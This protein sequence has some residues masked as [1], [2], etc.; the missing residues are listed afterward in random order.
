MKI[1][2]NA[3]KNV[4]AC[5][6]LFP[7]YIWGNKIEQ[8]KENTDLQFYAQYLGCNVDSIPQIQGYERTE[9]LESGD[10][11]STWKAFLFSCDGHNVVIMETNWLDSVHINRI[12]IVSEQIRKDDIFIGQSL[13]N[14]KKKYHLTLESSQDGF[15]LLRLTEYPYMILQ[16]DISM[17]S[18]GS[19][20]WMGECRLDEI[21]LNIVVETIIL[22]NKE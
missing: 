6:F 18:Q 14:L 7:I 12:T 1:R 5:T 8:V 20:L 17:T 11:G 9:Y 2:S 22:S 3:L 21:P 13:E 4:I 19:S 16:M 10:D 15:L